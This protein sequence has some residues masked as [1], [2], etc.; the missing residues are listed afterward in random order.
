MNETQSES[1]EQAMEAKPVSGIARRRLLR[2]GAAAVPVALTLSGRSAM[3]G[4]CARGLSP[5]AWNSLA[6]NGTNCY[7]ASHTVTPKTTGRDPLWWK[8]RTS[9]STTGAANSAF[10]AIFTT[11]AVTTQL[12]AVLD[13]NQTSYNAYFC[14]AYLNAEANPGGYPITM[15]ELK[16]LYNTKKLGNV[17]LTSEG[18]VTAFLLQTW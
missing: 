6:P 12:Y 13:A 16:A 4:T 17:T 3:A 14:A 11:S 18:Q 1:L 15:A 10:N 5:L 8:D 9:A 2:A 7:S